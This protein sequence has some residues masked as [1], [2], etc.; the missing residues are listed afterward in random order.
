MTGKGHL[1]LHPGMELWAEVV[2]LWRYTNTIAPI[3]TQYRSVA[4]KQ[5]FT[6]LCFKGIC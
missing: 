3:Y 6:T 4:W 5:L 2:R 1:C